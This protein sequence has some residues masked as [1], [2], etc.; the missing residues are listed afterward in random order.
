[1]PRCSPTG[2]SG[3]GPSSPGSSSTSSSSRAMSIPPTPSVS[4]WWSFITRAVWPPSS[5]SMNV[6]SH[7]GR[8]RSRPAMPVLRANSRTV[9]SVFGG[10]A[11]NRRTC[12]DRSK[13]GSTTQRG[14][15][16]RSGGNMTRCRNPGDS[17]VMRSS[18][19]GNRSQS[20]LPSRSSTHT[21]VERSSGSFSMYQENASLSRMCT[22][23]RSGNDITSPS[24]SDS[25]PREVGCQR[26]PRS[27]PHT[28]SRTSHRWHAGTTTTSSGTK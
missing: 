7:S 16:S 15:A 12:H 28:G 22:S 4:E 18:R 27:R 26:L 6:N 25:A 20:G 23:M 14:V 24:F 5:P 11:S 2:A 21:T 17:R 1:M 10:A 3:I 8:S 9:A 19:S 13:S